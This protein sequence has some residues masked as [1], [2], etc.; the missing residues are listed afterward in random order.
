MGSG[1]FR[2]AYEPLV[3]RLEHRKSSTEE[4]DGPHGPPGLRA[5]CAALALKGLQAEASA[6]HQGGRQAWEVQQPGRSTFKVFLRL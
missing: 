6:A 4:D 2:G 3:P 5:Q 1:C